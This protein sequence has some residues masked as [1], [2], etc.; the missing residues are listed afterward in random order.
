MVLNIRAKNRLELNKS[1]LPIS[2][3]LVDSFWFFDDPEVGLEHELLIY[4]ADGY[5]DSLCDM[6]FIDKYLGV[7][8]RFSDQE[9]DILG[10]RMVQLKLI[11]DSMGGNSYRIVK[12]GILN[13]VNRVIW[14]CENL[15][16]YF[17]KPP[18]ELFIS[19][20]EINCIDRVSKIAESN[21]YVLLSTKHHS[22]LEDFYTIDF[23]S[24]IDE[25]AR[26]SDSVQ[27]SNYYLFRS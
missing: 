17:E 8:I 13:N 14:L 4:G 27:W 26:T 11:G 18:E 16:K 15:S 2:P 7:G 23:I 19:F 6:H 5:L 21:G 22:T 12:D 3:F 24:D 25:I 9:S 20:D 1:E 10:Q